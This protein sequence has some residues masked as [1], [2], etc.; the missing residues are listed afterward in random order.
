[1]RLTDDQIK[2]RIKEIL[3]DDRLAY[4]TATIFGNAPLALIQITMETELH[5]LEKVLGL[6]LTDIKK[7]RKEK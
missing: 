2:A 3:A 4:K 7:L 5:T 6:P 1:M